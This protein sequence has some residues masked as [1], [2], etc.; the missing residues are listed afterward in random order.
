MNWSDLGKA[1]ADYGLPTLGKA[2]LGPAGALIG[3]GLASAIGTPSDAPMDILKAITED[4]EKSAAARRFELENET[5]LKRLAYAHEEKLEAED[6]ARIVAVNE[7]IREELKN[8][9]TEEWYQKAWRPFNGFAFGT[10]M[11]GC[12]FLLPL[13]RLPVPSV[14]FEAWAA[15]G[16]VLGVAS[17]WRGKQK[18]GA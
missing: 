12:Y 11:F 5:E 16:A 2:L 3:K 4:S 17:W 13:L 10:T 6:T 15:W 9:A 1:L 14:P 7:T 8:S 18:V